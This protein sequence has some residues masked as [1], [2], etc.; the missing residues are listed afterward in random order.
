MRMKRIDAHAHVYSNDN[1]RYPPIKNPTRPPGM[2]GSFSSLKKLADEN[3]V[4]KI[5]VIQPSSFYGWDNRFVCDVALAEPDNIAVI[6]TVNPDD[7]KAPALVS[8]LKKQYRI[9]G[10]RCF[11]ASNGH[12][13]HPGVRDIWRACTDEDITI[14]VLIDRSKAKELASLLDEF[15][16]VRCVIDHCLLLA[17]QPDVGR[18]LTALLKLARYPNAFAKLSALFFDDRE[19]YPYQSMQE[20][21]RRIISSYS[22][23]RCVW[24]SSFPC[25]LWTPRSTYRKNL[26]LFTSELAL[27]ASSQREIFWNTP[28][29]LWFG[30]T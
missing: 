2:S 4:S 3:E 27:D 10:I 24:G 19:R 20:P 11:P 1:V 26:E 6:C 21:L 18:T 25:E 29:R 30:T 14:N 12:L 5:C 15:S 17:A 22:P 13:N 16:G 8:H 7:R 23:S 9:R 28:S